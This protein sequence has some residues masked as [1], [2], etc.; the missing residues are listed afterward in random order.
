[1]RL[2]PSLQACRH[3]RR[4]RLAYCRDVS[5]L[6]FFSAESVPPAV[7][8]LSGLLAAAGQVVL[9]GSGARLSVVVYHLWRANALAEMI[10]E[11]GLEPEIGSTD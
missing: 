6:S 10:S 2:V 7:A 4:A 9:V 11:C 8:D 1:M 3:G 5:Q